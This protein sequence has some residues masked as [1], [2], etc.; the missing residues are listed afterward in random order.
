V[1][2]TAPYRLD[3]HDAAVE[4]TRGRY[5]LIALLTRACNLACSYCYLGHAKPVVGTRTDVGLAA[6]A[7]K[8]AFQQPW[9]EV[10]VDFG[11]IAV[12]KDLF[13]RLVPIAEEEAERTGKRLRM[14]IQTNGTPIDD[15]LGRYLAD[16]RVS[17]GLSMDGPRELHDAARPTHSGAGSY[18]A[19]HRALEICGEHGLALLVVCTVS[20][21]NVGHPERLFDHF[22]ELG[23]FGVMYKPVLA[24][25]EAATAWEAVGVQAAEFASFGVTLVRLAIEH[26][27][28]RLDE[29]AKR[30]L[31]RL[32]GDERGWGASCTSRTC[33]SGRSLHVV[34][35]SGQVFSCPRFV[36]EGAGLD[37]STQLRAER[38]QPLPD[39]LP[40]S[41]R[42]LPEAC[43]RCSWVR[44]CGGGCTLVGQE[45][46]GD[47]V[48]RMD[49]QCASY[50]AVH[51]ALIEEV[52]PAILGGRR[53]PLESTQIGTHRF[54]SNR[55]SISKPSRPLP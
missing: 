14:A 17:V 51:Q 19:A 10:L 42:L 7:I 25:G 48:P 4:E 40:T 3:L 41:L 13:R 27:L 34:H 32:V 52:V 46:L 39:L 6:G 28:D 16:H 30:F 24:T 38:P 47:A 43:K 11:E 5:S 45:G 22:A 2:G 8:Q 54:T 12:A 37:L 33:G 21:V 44:S 49:P 36:T 53:A 35:S 9:D 15:R 26:G 29:T 20:R 18:E 50:M 1:D 55:S 31:Y 23:E